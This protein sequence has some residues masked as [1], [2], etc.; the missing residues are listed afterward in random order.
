MSDGSMLHTKDFNRKLTS[1]IHMRLTLGREKK[2]GEADN[3][4]EMGRIF[5]QLYLVG[6]TVIVNK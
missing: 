6:L 5:I 1:L 4:H 3:M 2:R